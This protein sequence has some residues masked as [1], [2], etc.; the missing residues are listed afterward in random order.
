MENS[1]C[2]PQFAKT[3]VRKKN[4]LGNDNKK[5]FEKTPYI[6]YLLGCFILLLKSGNVGIY[7]IQGGLQ[8]WK[9]FST[10]MSMNKS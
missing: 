1:Y 10:V 7:I 4:E 6:S 8:L 9:E 2:K 5:K 3:V